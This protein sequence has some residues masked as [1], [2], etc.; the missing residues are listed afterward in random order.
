MY[1]L[2][3]LIGVALLGSRI[4]TTFS[5]INVLSF[6]AM[7]ILIVTLIQR[8]EQRKKQKKI[9]ELIVYTLEFFD[10]KTS[11]YNDMIDYIW[12]YCKN[13]NEFFDDE[14]LFKRDVNYFFIMYF[15]QNP[16]SK[17]HKEWYFFIYK[18]MIDINWKNKI[19]ITSSD[20][21]EKDFLKKL[22]WPTKKFIK[23]MV[24]KTEQ[25]LTHWIE[26]Y[27]QEIYK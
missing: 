23:S 4:Y 21:T 2:L 19:Y 27:K 20:S 12:F 17:E 22:D 16:P 26:L 6:A 9:R 24:E 15:I 7:Q 13:N 5:L 14:K 25:P 10:Y 1:I 11:K 3:L 18:K 8:E